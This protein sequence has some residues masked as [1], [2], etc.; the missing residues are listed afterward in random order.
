MHGPTSLHR[1]AF[2]NDRTAE[3]A[4]VANVGRVAERQLAD[5][6]NRAVVESTVGASD[7]LLEWHQHGVPANTVRGVANHFERIRTTG[8]LTNRL[9]EEEMRGG[10]GQVFPAH[11]ACVG[12]RRGLSR[13]GCRGVHERHV[14][15]R[16][17]RGRRGLTG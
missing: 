17:G 10:A 12:K 6:D 16:S 2:T 7:D 9:L 11:C 8:R 3:V 4:G 15:A 14:S 13:R 5:T 1:S